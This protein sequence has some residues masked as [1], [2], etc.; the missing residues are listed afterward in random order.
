M[1]G[2]DVAGVRRGS[3]AYLNV[4]YS[5][6]SLLIHIVVVLFRGK[7]GLIIIAVLSAIACVVAVL[8]RGADET[9]G[10][11]HDR[12]YDYRNSVL[13]HDLFIFS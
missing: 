2:D 6:S 1:H 5:Q 13:F 8:Y 10:H 4:F 7:R 12:D 3:G 9:C 11:Q